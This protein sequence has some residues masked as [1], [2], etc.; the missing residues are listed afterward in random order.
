MK[1][2]RLKF[3]VRYNRGFTLVETIVAIAIFAFA[4]TGLM[5]ITATG[6]F[7]TNYVKN[8]FTASYLALEGT[9]LVRSIRDTAALGGETWATLLSDT[10]LG[11][12][13]DST[14]CRID[15]WVAVPQ[16]QSCSADGS[17]C[18][19][20]TYDRD[21]AK[22]SYDAIDGIDKFESIFRRTITITQIAVNEI[23]I[24]S[25]VEWNQGREARS[26]VYT[27]NLTSWT[28]P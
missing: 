2:Q 4:I 27:Y 13:L 12:C 7:N 11:S 20:L 22:F 24:T 1:F 14:G 18:R 5:S 28:T 19:S 25:E 10:Y 21:S 9:E 16:A 26:V 23:Q 17:F 6:V 3:T 15:P 8:K